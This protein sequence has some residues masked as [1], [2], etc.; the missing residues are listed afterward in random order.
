MKLSK[1][2]TLLRRGS[3]LAFALV[4][5]RARAAEPVMFSSANRADHYARFYVAP[6]AREAWIAM[7]AKSGSDGK[8]VGLIQRG[9]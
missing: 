2:A 1:N 3:S 8:R 4:S 9:A 7:R 6:E 5:L